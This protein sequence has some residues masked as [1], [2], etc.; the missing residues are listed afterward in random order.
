MVGNLFMHTYSRQK[1]KV[2]LHY[3]TCHISNNGLLCE[4][5]SWVVKFNICTLEMN[6]VMDM[7]FF[8]VHILTCTNFEK[9]RSLL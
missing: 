6:F 2:W 3:F 7:F 9:S 5:L 8:I 4:M 1:L